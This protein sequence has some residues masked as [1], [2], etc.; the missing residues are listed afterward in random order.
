MNNILLNPGPTNTTEETKN[1]QWKGSDICHRTEDFFLLV[2][3]TKERILKRFS[4]D[5]KPSEWNVSLL[6][7]TGTTALEAMISSLI[8]R[9]ITVINAGKYGQRAMDIMQIYRMAYREVASKTIGDIEK[10][11]F[12]GN[13]YFVENETSTGEKYDVNIISK[14]YPNAKLFIDS[15]SAFGATDYSKSLE[16]IYSISLCSNKCLQSTPG[17]GIVIWRKSL[18]NME[19]NYCLNLGKYCKKMHLPFTL[20]TQSLFALNSS[21]VQSNSSLDVEKLFDKRRDKIISS[22]SEMNIECINK[23]PSNSIIAF[24]HPNKTYEELSEFLSSNG[25]VIYSGVGDMEKSFRVSTMSV[26][27]DEEYDK[28]CNTFYRS[29]YGEED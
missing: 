21:L 22:F 26:L 24:Q 6:G 25:I 4:P 29:V 27:F 28:I 17:L 20:P 7:G 15:T 16:S 9:D 5:A 14:K 10:S 8:V 23:S 3:D 19:R 12:S 13:L 18:D 11:D 2:E 1:A